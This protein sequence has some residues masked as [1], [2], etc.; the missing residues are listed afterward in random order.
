MSTASAAK[1]ALSSLVENVCEHAGLLEMMEMEMDCGEKK[2]VLER[3][4]SDTYEWKVLQL[5]Y[6]QLGHPWGG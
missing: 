2:T 6:I 5:V 3:L 1:Y 4:R